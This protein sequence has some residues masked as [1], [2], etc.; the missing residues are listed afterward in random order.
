MNREK[1]DFSTSQVKNRYDHKRNE[2]M[3]RQTEASS[4]GTT[5]ERLR[6]KQTS[7]N[8]LQPAFRPDSLAPPNDKRRCDVQDPDD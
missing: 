7:R 4:H 6:S 8:S 2:K 1:F 5:L 3:K